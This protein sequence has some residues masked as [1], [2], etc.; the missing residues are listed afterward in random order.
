MGRRKTRGK[1]RRSGERW[2]KDRE[3]EEKQEKAEGWGG[4]GSRG[5]PEAGRLFPRHQVLSKVFQHGDKDLTRPGLWRGTHIKMGERCHK[6][7]GP[8]GKHR[9]FLRSRLCQSPPRVTGQGHTA[10]QQQS[11]KL[12]AAT[13][14]K[15]ALA[16]RLE[17]A[18]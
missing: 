18:L 15:E 13:P 5:E 1:K 17:S 12:D 14:T 16:H 9:G 6:Y 11:Q 4:R 10:D 8:P 2:E 7:P 3:W